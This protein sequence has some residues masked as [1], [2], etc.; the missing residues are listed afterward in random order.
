[1]KD[2]RR[3]SFEFR[4]AIRF[5]LVFFLVFLLIIF[6]IGLAIHIFA[7]LG[8]PPEF[9][10][11]FY[12]MMT[13]LVIAC[14]FFGTITAF[15][16]MRKS[17]RKV[18]E[19]RKVINNIA[20]GE[21]NETLE[22]DAVDPLYYD[23]I[24]DFN[25]MILELQSNTLMKK[26]F[27]SN[28]SHEFKTPIVS[29]KGYAELLYE[30]PNL[31]IETRNTYL[32]II[33]EESRRLAKLSN[34][35]MLLSKLDSTEIVEHQEEYYLDEQINECVLLLDQELQNKDLDVALSLKHLKFLGNKD[36]LKEVWI[37]LLNNAIKFSS[38]G[39]KISINASVIENKIKVTV[40][41]NGSGMNDDVAKHIFD[42]YYQADSSHKGKG[43]GLGLSITKRIVEL[44][45]GEINVISEEGIGTVFTVILP[46]NV[47]EKNNKTQE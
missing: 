8:Y 30:T 21:F 22:N 38:Q 41:D 46:K 33:I 12:T 5:S 40:A 23:M 35:T 20:N 42:R 14:T 45:G 4:S 11:D 15:I 44:T 17:M 26:D 19:I 34:Q 32:K 36:M 10:F 27:I 47:L 6:F 25:K 37:N 24:D 31:D 9:F 1:M 43:I 7:R 16:L 18:N 3:I 28:F 13:M 39:G 2:D 29:I